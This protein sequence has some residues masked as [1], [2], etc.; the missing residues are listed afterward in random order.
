[1]LSFCD[2]AGSERISKTKNVG[3]RQKKAGRQHQQLSP[4]LWKEAD[5]INRFLLGCGRRQTTST[6]FS[7]VVEGGRQHQQLS[8]GLWAETGNINSSLLGCGRRP[9]NINSSLLVVGRPGNIN[10]SLPVVDGGGHHQQLLFFV[11][12]RRQATST[13]LSWVV[14]GG[15]P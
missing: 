14:A 5:N 9:G 8:P 15:R 6:T 2:L 13:A 7:W 12:E 11:G 4:G 10:S 1:M 3:E